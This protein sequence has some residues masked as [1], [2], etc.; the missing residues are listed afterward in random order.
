MQEADPE[1]CVSLLKF[2]TM[3]EFAFEYQILGRE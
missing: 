3:V 1:I 2:L